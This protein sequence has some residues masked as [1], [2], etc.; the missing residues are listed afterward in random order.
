MKAPFKRAGLALA[1]AAPLLASAPAL[2]SNLLIKTIT[3]AQAAALGP[4]LQSRDSQRQAVAIQGNFTY[5]SGGTSA[6]A[7]VQTSLDSGAT[8]TDVVNFHFT[9]ASARFIYNL[10]GL[11]PK[12][13]EVVPT[14]G[15]LAANTSLD[16]VVGPLWR[17]KYTTVG[18]YAASTTLTIDAQFNMGRLVP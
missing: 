17:V 16:G 2:A 5:G 9:T 6:D 3:T 8:W 12:T 7:Y 4:V 18:T 14:D 11:T 15:A 13:T 10:S 1:L